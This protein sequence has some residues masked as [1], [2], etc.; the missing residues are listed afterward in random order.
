MTQSLARQRME[1]N[2]ERPRGISQTPSNRSD[3]AM[4][5]I[6]K[7]M[8]PREHHDHPPLGTKPAL[9]TF[10][11]NPFSTCFSAEKR[12]ELDSYRTTDPVSGSKRHVERI[13]ERKKEEK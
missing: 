4:P 1:A 8:Y 5:S 9:S 7:I 6:N 3:N 13:G 10:M 11:N 2:I 12:I